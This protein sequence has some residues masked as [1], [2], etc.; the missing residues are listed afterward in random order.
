MVF[1]WQVEA[2]VEG[3]KSRKSEDL[4]TYMDDKCVSSLIV[5][6]FLVQFSVCVGVFF[7]P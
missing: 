2:S 1:V 4:Q 3:L 6:L 7:V 5:Y